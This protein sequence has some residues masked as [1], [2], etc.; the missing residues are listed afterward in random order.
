MKIEITTNAETANF[1]LE[2][3][4]LFKTQFVNANY[5]TGKVMIEVLFPPSADAESIAM[6]F[7]LAGQSYTMKQVQK[8][9]SNENSLSTQ[10]L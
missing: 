8:I 2:E 3:K 9:F 5:Q 4:R 6:A 10:T 7:F 1:L